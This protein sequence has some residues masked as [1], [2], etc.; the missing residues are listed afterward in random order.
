MYD[1][2]LQTALVVCSRLL[3]LRFEGS[4][5]NCKIKIKIEQ[6]N[7]FS[8]PISSLSYVVPPSASHNQG[9]KKSARTLVRRTRQRFHQVRLFASQ[10]AKFARTSQMTPRRPR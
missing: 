6:R 1:V 9:T 8:Q 4:E 7:V 2:L 10:S 5:I 3:I